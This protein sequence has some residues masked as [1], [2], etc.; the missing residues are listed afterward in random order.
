[1]SDPV[2]R[3]RPRVT[4]HV[5]PSLPRK[6]I[7]PGDTAAEHAQAVQKSGFSARTVSR[8]AHAVAVVATI[9]TTLTIGAE[10]ALG[11]SGYGYGGGDSG[12]GALLGISI[13]CGICY[14]AAGGI[15]ALAKLFGDRGIFSSWRRSFTWPVDLLGEVLALPFAG[16]GALNTLWARHAKGHVLAN[17][18]ATLCQSLEHVLQPSG[19]ILDEYPHHTD[20]DAALR[21]VR[22][23]VTATASALRAGHL[24]LAVHI[25]KLA[26]W[27][28][29]DHLV[30]S[31]QKSLDVLVATAEEC[32]SS[33][34][35]ASVQALFGNGPSN[36]THDPDLLDRSVP[37]HLAETWTWLSSYVFLGDGSAPNSNA[38]L[39]LAS[40]HRLF[41]DFGTRP[42]VRKVAA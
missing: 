33:W 38:R 23:A 17:T 30:E 39:H 18:A 40:W 25:M 35:S 6:P 24:D 5:Q 13:G 32:R 34:K 16:L 2:S 14:A 9:A 31:D 3:N 15:H 12:E 28:V 10:R 1:M 27:R 29:R 11:L 42:E 41:D 19:A 22:S 36:P 26:H 8:G 20:R 21:S 4:P 7:V 37:E